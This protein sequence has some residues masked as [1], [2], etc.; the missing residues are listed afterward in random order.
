MLRPHVSM[1]VEVLEILHPGLSSVMSNRALPWPS[2]GSGQ[3]G[4]CCSCQSHVVP[5]DHSKQK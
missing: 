3:T 5:W 1:C 2:H 4:F